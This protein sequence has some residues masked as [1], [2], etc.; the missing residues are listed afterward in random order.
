MKA[1]E[2]KTGDTKTSYAFT[3]A[4]NKSTSS[5]KVAS[6]VLEEQANEMQKN[7][8]AKIEQVGGNWE[9]LSN[10]AM[11]SKSGVSSN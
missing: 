11:A 7:V 1:V 10:K 3:G 2:D 9:S 6:K 5:Q 8:G 4:V